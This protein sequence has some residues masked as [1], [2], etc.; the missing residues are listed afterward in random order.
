[1]MISTATSDGAGGDRA[2]LGKYSRTAIGFSVNQPRVMRIALADRCHTTLRR[3]RRTKPEAHGAFV[4]NEGVTSQQMP[5]AAGGGTQAEIVFFAI[6]AA[7]RLCVEPT[8]IG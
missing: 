3:S 5:P 6:A 2:V 7:K 8:D 4:I 1:M